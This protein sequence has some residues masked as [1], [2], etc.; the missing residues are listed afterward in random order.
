MLAKAIYE[1]AWGDLGVNATFLALQAAPGV[2]CFLE[3]P[4]H[5]SQAFT[6]GHLLGSLITF[7][8]GLGYFPL[9]KDAKPLLEGG[10]EVIPEILIA[11]FAQV[12]A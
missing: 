2:L 8:V 7:G 6:V 12:S 11:I 9:I 4:Q 1:R 5:V 3:R 10:K